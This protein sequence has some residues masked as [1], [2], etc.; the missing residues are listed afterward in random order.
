MQTWVDS[1][2]YTKYGQPDRTQ[3]TDKHDLL[4]RMKTRSILV[5]EKFRQTIWSDFNIELLGDV[6]PP[7]ITQATQ[8]FVRQK[9]GWFYYCDADYI[10]YSM[11]DSPLA[12]SPERVYFINMKKMH[13]NFADF[14]KQGV[15]SIPRINL[16]GIGYSLNL[17]IPW[18]VLEMNKIATKVYQKEPTSTRIT[19]NLAY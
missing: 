18:D 3:E 16:T 10:L 7:L 15:Y 12:E 1:N 4:L 6:V 13:E 19:E 5:E 17:A 8:K 11:N 2:I 14:I 9:I